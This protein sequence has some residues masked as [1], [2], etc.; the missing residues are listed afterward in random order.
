MDIKPGIYFDVPNSEYR[1][2]NAFAQSGVRHIL[3]S[4]AHYMQ[5][6]LFE[7]VKSKAMTIGSLIDCLVL[8]PEKYNSYF[9][10]IPET[11]INSKEEI[12]EFNANSTVCKQIKNEILASGKTIID[13]NQINI[14]QNCFVQISGHKTASEIIARSKKQVSLCWIDSDTGVLCKGRL[15]MLDDNCDISDLK[16]TMDA[17]PFS[18]SKSIESFGY[19]I[20]GA[21]YSDGYAALTGNVQLPY[22]IIA[23]ETEAPYC[24][25]TYVIEPDTLLIGRCIYKKALKKYA[26]CKKLNSWP[27][28]SDFIEPIDVPAWAIKKGL[29]DVEQSEF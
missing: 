26:E 11:Y 20:Q 10:V 19:H 4:P 25:A 2:W 14:A 22:N 29:E 8:E 23:V 12:K 3:R 6:N 16:S 9:A 17:S 15:D 28:Y 13:K 27:G 1:A 7:S 21:F 24:V 18:F 5:N